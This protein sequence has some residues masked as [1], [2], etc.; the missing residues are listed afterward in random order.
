MP[1]VIAIV[2]CALAAWGVIYSRRGSVAPACL[3]A[4]LAAYVFGHSFWNFDLGPIPLTIDRLLLAAICAVDVA[5]RMSGRLAATPVGGVDWLLFA[6]L[7]LVTVSLLLNPMP[8]WIT[9][10]GSPPGRLLACFLVPAVAYW[11][12]RQARVTQRQWTI[13]VVTLAGLGIYLAITALAEASQQWWAVFPKY[14]ADPD[15]G[16]HFGRARGPALNSASLGSYLAASFVGAWMVARHLGGLWRLLPVALLPCYAAATYFTYTRSVWLAFAL[17]AA[18]YVLDELRGGWRTLLISGMMATSLFFVTANWDQLLNLRR[19]GD[20]GASR[21]SIQ[22][23][24]SFLHVSWNMFCDHPIF[25]VGFGRFYDRKTPYLADRRQEVELDSLHSLQHHNTFL[26]VLTETGMV[27]LAL[28][29]GLLVGWA[30]TAWA[31]MRDVS[32]PSWV[33]CHGKFMLAILVIYGSSALFHDLTQQP[34]EQ[35]LLLFAAGLT[36]QKAAPGTS[37]PPTASAR[38]RPS[39][40]R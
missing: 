29:L 36:V 32:L 30:K 34:A 39:A 20:G 7:A 40:I 28:M 5:Q 10:G 17:C 1:V 16:T 18:I 21:H 26:S 27:G 35:M 22:Q 33:R 13:M 2:A 12:I 23:R 3:V 11:L 14:I 19:E 8:H 37:R 9:T 4:V 31:L 6:L 38:P 15:A 25:G 24:T